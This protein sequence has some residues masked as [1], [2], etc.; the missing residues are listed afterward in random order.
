[1]SV[2]FWVEYLDL[3]RTKWQKDGEAGMEEGS[4]AL[5]SWNPSLTNSG[6]QDNFPATRY[7]V[8]SDF[9]CVPIYSKSIHI[10]EASVVDKIL[11]FTWIIPTSLTLKYG[12]TVHHSWKFFVGTGLTTKIVLSSKHFWFLCILLL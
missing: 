1:M 5:G 11:S 9:C 12:S 2:G 6:I 10:A 4:V 3:R 7:V 8:P